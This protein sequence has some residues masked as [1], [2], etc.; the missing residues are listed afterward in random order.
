MKTNIRL[1]VILRDKKQVVKV[2]RTPPGK[3]FTASGIENV[4]R[5]EA[6]LVEE[7]F[8]DREF[9]LVPLTGGQFNFVEIEKEKEAEVAS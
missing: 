7:F 3:V 4:L 5:Q 8:P 9:R 2:V 1:K 6:E